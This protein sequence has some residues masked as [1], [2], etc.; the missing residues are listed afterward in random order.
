MDTS[1]RQ[2]D[3]PE[4]TATYGAVRRDPA[5]QPPPPQTER[6]PREEWP[7][8][9]GAETAPAA[10]ASALDDPAYERF[11]GVNVGAA[12]FGWMVAVGTTVLLSGI[13]GAVV[14]VLGLGADVELDTSSALTT[15]SIVS[16]AVVLGVLLVAYYC[17]GY[18]A[19]RM[20][21]F[22]GGRQGVA[23]W[24]FALVFGILGGLAGYAAGER[25]DLL[26]GADLPSVEVA[27]SD[28]TLAGIVTG[29]VVLLGTLLAAVVGGKVGRRYHA[30]VDRAL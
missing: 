11:G 29:V 7:R 27:T 30:K 10:G 3:E 17:G 20:S 9:A 15:T 22:D 26:S 4:P 21:R 24:L 28:L 6:V 12:F 2:P 13:V 16:A 19:G 1:R 18:V 5:Q 8:P 25:Y 23:V 14:L